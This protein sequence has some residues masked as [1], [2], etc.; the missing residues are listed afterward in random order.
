MDWRPAC[1][2]SHRNYLDRI[3]ITMRK[4]NEA[5]CL[6]WHSI[7]MARNY[8][9]RRFFFPLLSLRS[10]FLIN[11]VQTS[12]IQK[13]N[14][15]PRVIM[16]PST[17]THKRTTETKKIQKFNN[18]NEFPFGFDSDAFLPQPPPHPLWFYYCTIHSHFTIDV[19]LFILIEAL[20]WGFWESG[21]NLVDVIEMAALLRTASFFFNGL[22]LRHTIEMVTIILLYYDLVS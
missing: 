16:K 15:T 7:T 11:K 4:E 3:E 10:S 19:W 12:N 14:Q 8:R 6:Q 20:S 18:F 21:N 22:W 2:K 9:K 5:T 1:G 17:R 13:Q